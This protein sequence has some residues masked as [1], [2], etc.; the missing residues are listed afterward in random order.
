MFIFNEDR[1]MM[2]KFQNLVVQDVNAPDTGRPVEVLWLDADV[3]LANLTFPSIVISNTGIT[4]AG[5][6]AHAG[7]FQ[8]QYAPEGFNRWGTDMTDVTQSPYYAQTPIPYNINYQIEVLARNNKHATFLTSVLSGPDFLHARYGYLSIPEDGTVRRMDLTSGPERQS[9]H[10]GDGKR[11][12]HSVYSINVSTE[13]LPPEIE[14]YSKVHTVVKD[15]SLLPP[16][17]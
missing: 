4:Y 7:W 13:L 17:I 9:I 3:E 2:D 16:T 11:L 5:E 6:R 1:A 8:L 15:I 12:F 14:S 10:D